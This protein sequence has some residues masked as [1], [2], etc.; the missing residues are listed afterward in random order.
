MAAAHAELGRHRWLVLAPHPDDETLGAGA[1]IASLRQTGEPVAVAFLTDGAASHPGSATHSPARLRQL[2]RREAC[3][4]LRALNGSTRGIAPVFLDWPDAVPFA[5]GT[6]PFA[7]TVAKLA[8]ICRRDRITALATTWSGEPHCDHAAAFAVADAVVRAS[9]G[10]LALYQYLVWGWGEPGVDEGLRAL[11]LDGRRSR[12]RRRMA[13]SRH[14][15]QTQA[16]VTDSADAFRL[17]LT[18]IRS[19]G[20]PYDLIFARG[21]YRAAPALA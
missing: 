5:A 7:A 20:R 12:A 8:A 3:A 4:A 9:F 6:R 1:L 16:L 21:Q 13:I 14:R 19:A 18:M 10:R 17:P 15:S 11:P 2:R